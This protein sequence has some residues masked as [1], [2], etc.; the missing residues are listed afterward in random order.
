MLDPVGMGEGERERE[1]E[2][3]RE[4]EREKGSDKGRDKW[5]GGAQQTQIIYTTFAYLFP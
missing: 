1:E 3:E 4:R 5:V 2:R